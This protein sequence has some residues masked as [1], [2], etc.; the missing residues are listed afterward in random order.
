VGA[1]KEE[2]LSMCIVCK[3][4]GKPMSEAT[5][6]E[7]ADAYKD[8]YGPNLTTRKWTVEQFIEWFPADKARMTAKEVEAFAYGVVASK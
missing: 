5:D 3:Y 6:K 8:A 7:R 4:T 1:T 2:G